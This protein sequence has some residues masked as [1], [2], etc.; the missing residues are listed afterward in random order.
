MANHNNK[1]STSSTN[2]NKNIGSHPNKNTNKINSSLDGV[3]K[4]QQKSKRIHSDSSVSDNPTSPKP[5]QIRKKLFST[6]NRFEVLSQNVNT[7]ENLDDNLIDLE[8]PIIPD[9]IK[10][11]PPIFVKGVEDF[12]EL[13][14]TLIELIG[15][16]NFICKSTSDCLKIQTTNPAAYRELVRFL[17]DEK[18]EF[19]TY[20]LKEDKPLR[21]V[22]RNLHPTIPLNLIKEELTVRLFEKNLINQKLLANASIANNMA[23][24]EHIVAIN[25]DV[26][27]V[28]TSTSL[29]FVLTHVII[30]QNVHIVQKTIQPTT[31]AV[32]FTKRFNAGKDAAQQEGTLWKTTKQ[33]LHYKA[34]NLPIKKSDGSLACSDTEKADLFKLHL[35]NT[36]QPHSNIS[37][38]AHLNT[39]D[40]FLNS[41]LPVSLPVK[42]FTPNDIKYTI[43]KSSL[44]KSPGFDLITDEVARCLPKK[45]IVHISH[46]YNAILRLSYFP[47]LWKFSTI[48]LVPKPNKPPDLPSSYRPISLLPFFAKILERLILKRILPIIM[49][50]NVLPDTQFGF[51]AS[52]STIHQFYDFKAQNTPNSSM[53]NVTLLSAAAHPL[54]VWIDGSVITIITPRNPE[55]IRRA[56]GP[57]LVRRRLG[58]AP[59]VVAGG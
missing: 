3:W 46:I 34:P 45:A 56:S 52:H 2:V 37:D 18:A 38:V 27:A 8:P 53:R 36:F 10:P 20:Q 40:E 54:R 17:R 23:T 59:L 47:L 33:I 51:R 58:G 31:R 21:V 26:S 49:E 24:L 19:H 1:P 32:Q 55:C 43:Q 12:P 5:Q 15:V 42:P 14:L 25:P 35:F 41:P 29:L 48:I 50:N 4:T 22:I 16:D 13:C 44:N 39:V 6:T 57:L 9:T 7:D 28:V 30:L 11:P